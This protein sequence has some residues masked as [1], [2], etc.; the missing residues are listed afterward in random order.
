MKLFRHPTVDGTKVQILAV[1]I[2]FENKLYI[3]STLISASPAFTVD[4]KKEHF[5]TIEEFRKIANRNMIAPSC[6]ITPPNKYVSKCGRA[7]TK[8]GTAPHRG[9]GAC[10]SALKPTRQISDGKP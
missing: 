6:V 1:N 3:L 8:C 5:K 2:D 7:D 10:R 4:Q 9:T